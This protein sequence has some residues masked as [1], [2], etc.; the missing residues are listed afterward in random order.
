MCYIQLSLLGIPA[1]VIHGNPLTM[2]EWAH[3]YTRFTSCM[4][5]ITGLNNQTEPE[6]AIV[7]HPGKVFSPDDQIQLF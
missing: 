2:Q 6:P 1:V 3:W 7:L 5:G 4:A